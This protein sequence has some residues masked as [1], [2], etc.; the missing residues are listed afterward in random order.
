MGIS[1][2]GGYAMNASQTELRINACAGVSTY[3]LGYTS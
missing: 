3:N 1:A 2:G